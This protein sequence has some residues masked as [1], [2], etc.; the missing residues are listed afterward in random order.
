MQLCFLKKP[1]LD[2]DVDATVVV[3]AAVGVTVAVD[4]VASAVVVVVHVPL[5]YFHSLIVVPVA[6]PIWELSE[7]KRL[8][9]SLSIRV[10]KKLV[11]F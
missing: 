6:G 4:V 9:L 2:I 7:T 5:Q 1:C 8:S 10:R 11:I 3:A